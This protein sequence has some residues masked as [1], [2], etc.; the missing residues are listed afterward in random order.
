MMINFEQVLF[1]SLVTGSLYLLSGTDLTLTYGLSRFPN[2]AYAEF[3]TLGG[4]IGYIIIEQAKGS[5]PLGF[6]TAFILVGTLS[7]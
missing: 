1:N 2:F 3:I 4:F 6:L 7:V 5:F